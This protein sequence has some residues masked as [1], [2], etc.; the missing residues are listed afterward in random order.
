M[1]RTAT[2]GRIVTYLMRV[3]KE[4][5]QWAASALRMCSQVPRGLTFLSGPPNFRNLWRFGLQG[6]IPLPVPPGVT[7]IAE[8]QDA[9]LIDG[10]NRRGGQT[11]HRQG[12][13]HGAASPPARRSRCRAMP[14]ESERQAPLLL[15]PGDGDRRR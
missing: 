4:R 5:R 12:G 2:R 7:L 10:P 15:G 14:D 9:S 1:P 13:G 11:R 6:T 3:S 8:L